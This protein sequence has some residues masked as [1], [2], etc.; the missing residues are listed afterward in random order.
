MNEL[1]R[2]CGPVGLD[3]LTAEPIANAAP[4][5]EQGNFTSSAPREPLMDFVGIF[6]GIVFALVAF[7]LVGGGKTGL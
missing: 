1:S 6:A 4:T 2:I 5:M 3:P 7:S